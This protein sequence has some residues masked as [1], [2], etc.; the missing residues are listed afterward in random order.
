MVKK[1]VLVTGVFDPIHSGHIEYFE[2]AKKL[3]DILIVGLNSD[4]WLQRKKGRPF[5]LLQERMRIVTS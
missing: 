3:G 5:M 2:A 4:D 1:V